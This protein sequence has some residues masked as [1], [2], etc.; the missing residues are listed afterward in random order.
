MMKRVKSLFIAASIVAVVVGSIQIAGNFFDFGKSGT[1]NV[2]TTNGLDAD[3]V[4]GGRAGSANHKRQR[5]CQFGRQSACAAEAVRD[6]RKFAPL[7]GSNIIATTPPLDLSPAAQS[8]PSLLNPPAL[9][10][11]AF[12]IEE[13]HHRVDLAPGPA[14]QP[15]PSNAQG[16]DRLP[17]AIGGARLRSAAIAGDGAAAYEVAVRFAEGR[18]VPVNLEEAAHW[19]ERA[20]SK[21]LAPRNSA[22]PACWKRARA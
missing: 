7:P 4:S 6:H 11:P 5:A 2:K 3:A 19:F 16:P 10:T 12:G 13:R 8:L 14:R 18:G 1:G 17:I 21:G 15:A 22:M 20:A 9:N